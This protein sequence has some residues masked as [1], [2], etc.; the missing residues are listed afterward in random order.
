M[1]R[2]GYTPS[3]TPPTPPVGTA[4]RL[5]ESPSRRVDPQGGLTPEVGRDSLLSL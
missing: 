1:K 5:K 2:G 4:D 3:L